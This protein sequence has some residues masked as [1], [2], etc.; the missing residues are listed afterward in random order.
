MVI[1]TRSLKVICTAHE[2]G[3]EHDFQ[4]LKRSKVKP[5]KVEI[6]ADK[7]YREIK[8]IQTLSYTPIK[9]NK[10]TVLRRCKAREH[11][12]R[13]RPWRISVAAPK[14]SSPP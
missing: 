7:G 13:T 12:F 6:F 4:L 9:K 1:E 11:L 14:G 3:K 8:K 10:E 2:T 5:L